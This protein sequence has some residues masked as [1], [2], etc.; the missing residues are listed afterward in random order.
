[1]GLNIAKLA[2]EFLPVLGAAGVKAL[3]EE[4]TGLASGQDGW[5][6][7]V[8][9]LMA[10]AISTH[11]PEGIQV[12]MDAINKLLDADDADVPDLDMAQEIF[13]ARSTHYRAN[14]VALLL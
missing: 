4:L 9:A 5:K 2:D 7:D 10:D 12:A 8:L 3:T 1:M 14:P 11:G 6:K 13:N